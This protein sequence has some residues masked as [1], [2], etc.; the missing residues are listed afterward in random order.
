VITL[1]QKLDALATNLGIAEML[2]SVLRH[3]SKENQAHATSEDAR[4]PIRVALI[5]VMEFLVAA[6]IGDRRAPQT[7]W[8]LLRAFSELDESKSVSSLFRADRTGR[9]KP[10][11][12][13]RAIRAVASA[14]LQLRYEDDG[15][16]EKASELVEQAMAYLGAEAPSASAIRQWRNAVTNRPTDEEG[17]YYYNAALTIL[18]S[19]GSQA[20]QIARTDAAIRLLSQAD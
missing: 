16:L 8:H 4:L 2:N 14:Q 12:R 10:T 20:E 5:A 7:L 11:S 19:C 15:Q 9:P 3:A 13:E 1:Q 18:R 17:A 6:G